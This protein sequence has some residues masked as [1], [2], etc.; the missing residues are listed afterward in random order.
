MSAIAGPFSKVAIPLSFLQHDT[1]ER[2][3]SL[4]NWSSA[5]MNERPMLGS[6]G[7]GMSDRL[8][9]EAAKSKRPLD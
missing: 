2:I 6:E 4:E 3:T 8:W 7:R 1:N 5:K 9:V